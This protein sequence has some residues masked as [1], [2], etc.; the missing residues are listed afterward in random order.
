MSSTGVDVASKPTATPQTASKHE[1]R[2]KPHITDTPITWDNWFKHVNWL[3]VYFIGGLP[4]I[5]LIASFW[6]PLKYQTAIWAVVYY[7]CTGLGK[8][9]TLRL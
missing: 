4:L 3:N 7:F 2:P 9:G 5:G 6:T 1:A 8:L